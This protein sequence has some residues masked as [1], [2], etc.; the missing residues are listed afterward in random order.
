MG[1]KYDPKKPLRTIEYFDAC[2]LYGWSM[3]EY[4]PIGG[5]MWVDVSRIDDWVEFI[6]N[7]KDDQD[8]GYMLDVDLEY[9]EDLHDLHDVY[10]LAPEK[11]KIKEEYLSEYQKELGRGCVVKFGAEK[12]C[13]ALN[14]KKDIHFI[15]CLLYTSPS[16]RDAHESRMPSSA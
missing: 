9:P 10:P 13:P 14:D 11:I 4:L 5:S 8:V 16:P 3:S 15:I 6:L 7:L 2:N 1:E 12:L